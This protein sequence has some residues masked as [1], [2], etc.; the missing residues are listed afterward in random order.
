V[1]FIWKYIKIIYRTS[2]SFFL[3]GVS[4]AETVTRNYGLDLYVRRTINNQSEAKESQV[5]SPAGSVGSLKIGGVL[6]FY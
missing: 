5:S 4:S 1:I 3:K 2:C 6:L